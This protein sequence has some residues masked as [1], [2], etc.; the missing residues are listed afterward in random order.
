MLVL[1]HTYGHFRYI[2]EDTDTKQTDWEQEITP[3]CCLLAFSRL[4]GD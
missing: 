4:Y 3:V 2:S 1:P